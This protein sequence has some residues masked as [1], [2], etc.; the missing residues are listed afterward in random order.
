M[1]RWK[2]GDVTV[3]S[4]CEIEA[5]IPGDLL[6]AGA[7]TEAVAGFPWLRPHF[8]ADDGQI[9]MRIQ[10]LVVESAGR[11]I[12][13]DT[14]V[15]NDKQGRVNPAFDLLQTPFLADLAAAGFERESI[16]TV[17]HT[18]LHVDH[19]GWNTMLVDSAWVPTFPNARHLIVGSEW[20]HWCASPDPNDHA[21][22]TD[23]IRP[24]IDAGL[25]DLV[26]P[27]HQVTPEVRL[28]PTPVH[29]PGHVSV[30]ID[31]G[32]ARAVITGDLMHHPVQCARPEWCCHFDV[33]PEQA[34]AT[35][36]AFVEQHAG[37]PVLVIGTHFS[38]PVAGY[39]VGG[40]DDRRFDPAPSA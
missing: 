10:A 33:D 18:H 15:G 14:C 19:V 16:D 8:A 27:G 11:R 34:R 28:A 23:S 32:G 39:V 7:T 1:L 6:I 13:V 2:V 21:V 26:E 22:V 5:T 12:V 9:V 40:P 25:A 4:V 3:T 30:G 35:R 36:R 31:S 17:V 38:G 24:V 37:R 20:A 29:T